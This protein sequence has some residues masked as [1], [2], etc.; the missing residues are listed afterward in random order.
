MDPTL[1]I[2]LTL[3][4]TIFAAV[5]EGIIG[6]I[7]INRI[8][9]KKT[10]NADKPKKDKKTRDDDK[11]KKD[12]K[13]RDD[14]KPKKDEKTGDDD[15]LQKDEKPIIIIIKNNIVLSITLLLLLVYVGFTLPGLIKTKLSPT[16]TITSTSAPTT[17]PSLTPLPPCNEQISISRPLDNEQI[18]ASRKPTGNLYWFEA[19]GEYELCPLTENE[20]PPDWSILFIT[21]INS[22]KCIMAY[23]IPI[24]NTNDGKWKTSVPVLDTASSNAKVFDPAIHLSITIYLLQDQQIE[25][26]PFPTSCESSI[27][28]YGFTKDYLK[29]F[30]PVHLMLELFRLEDTST[31]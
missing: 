29:Q 2:I 12:K 8:Q 17:T 25:D 23:Q 28:D 16:P 14:D 6:P 24:E 4:S 10:G 31:H 7:I 9:D 5:I 22:P 27:E 15:K 3:L 19:E 11:P 20:E 1:I 26:F 30:T 13:T 18:T 21:T